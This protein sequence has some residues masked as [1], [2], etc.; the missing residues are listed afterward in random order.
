MR[1]FTFATLAM[2]LA[3]QV[4]TAQ[5]I[6]YNAFVYTS[7][8]LADEVNVACQEAVDEQERGLVEDAGLAAYSSAKGIA[9]GYVTS[10]F[11]MGVNALASLFT[12][13]S[14]NKAEWL[15]AVE[16]ESSWSH[17]I[18][19]VDGLHDFYNCGSKSGALDP[20]G[21]SFNGIG[22]V[23]TEGKDTVFYI[24]CHIN[25]DREKLKRIVNHS[26]FELVLDT[27]IVSPKRSNLP[28]TTLDLDYSFADR[29]NFNLAVTI[30]LTSSWFT[31]EIELHNDEQLGEFTINIP[32]REEDL[33]DKGFLRY[34]RKENEEGKYKVKGESFIVPRSYICYRDEYDRVIPFWGTGEYNISIELKETCEVT[35]DF[36]KR[37]KDD[38]K[39]R[40]QVQAQMEDKDDKKGFLS[41]KWQTITAQDWNANLQQWTITT[42]TAPA[43]VISQEIN[44]RLGLTTN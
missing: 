42:L 9:G 30:K 10:F 26:K 27:L 21:M 6:E 43:D 37:W 7:A 33:D 39:K 5:C 29:G 15:A 22:C 17:T 19:N 16:A 3:Y 34:V 38:R 40:E 4:M 35:N 1:R 24:S 20:Q 25:Q 23:R 11:T 32:I 36:K 41:E 8:Q 2:L 13:N 44:R 14:K 12:Q 18:E 31:R 28:N